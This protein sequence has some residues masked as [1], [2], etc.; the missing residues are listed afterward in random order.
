[1]S[2]KTGTASANS[3]ASAVGK[4]VCDGTSTSSPGF[5]PSARIAIHRAAVPEFVRTAW[6]VPT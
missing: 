4:A 1:M 5:T 6:R 2:T 3:T